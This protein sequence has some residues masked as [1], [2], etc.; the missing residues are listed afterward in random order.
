MEEQSQDAHWASHVSQNMPSIRHDCK[1]K[2][3]ME[4]IMGFLNR[5]PALN[6]FKD[7]IA[8]D[9]NEVHSLMGPLKHLIYPYNNYSD[10]FSSAA[11]PNFH[12]FARDHIN[13]D[14]KLSPDEI[15]EAIEKTGHG[16]MSLDELTTAI[17]G[18]KTFGEMVAMIDDVLGNKSVAASSETLKVLAD[19]TCNDAWLRAVRNGSTTNFIKVCLSDMG[20]R[21]STHSGVGSFDSVASNLVDIYAEAGRAGYI[22][23]EY[24]LKRLG[25]R[26]RVKQT[27]EDGD[28]FVGDSCFFRSDVRLPL[29]VMNPTIR[30]AVSQIVSNLEIRLKHIVGDPTGKQRFPFTGNASSLMQTLTATANTGAMMAAIAYDPSG[31][32]IFGAPVHEPQIDPKAIPCC[33][34]YTGQQGPRKRNDPE[35]ISWVL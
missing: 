28:R 32:F 27:P 11:F 3:E 30:H 25:W 9:R 23:V 7:S 24:E 22:A 2:F 13:L 6:K 29:D 17:F 1:F 15:R 20:G 34:F 8:P 16:S 12:G 14:A 26:F 18:F 33:I 19:A 4:A 21:K 35:K 10:Y 31:C 5:K